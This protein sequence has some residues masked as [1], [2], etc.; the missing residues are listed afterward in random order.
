VNGTNEYALVRTRAVGDPVSRLPGVPW[1]NGE[2][3]PGNLEFKFWTSR[4]EQGAHGEMDVW[5][6]ERGNV[7]AFFKVDPFRT[8]VLQGGPLDVLF[9]MT[10]NN[11][12]IREA[13]RNSLQFLDQSLKASGI[14][15][16]YGIILM[17]GNPNVSGATGDEFYDYDAFTTTAGGGYWNSANFGWNFGDQ[18]AGM[19]TIKN[20]GTLMDWTPGASRVYVVVTANAAYDYPPGYVE[21]TSTHRY[22]EALDSLNANSVPLFGIV[23][24]NAAVPINPFTFVLPSNVPQSYMAM[25][26]ATGGQSYTTTDFT[27]NGTAIMQSLAEAMRIAS[28]VVQIG[29]NLN[30]ISR[31]ALRKVFNGTEA[32]WPYRYV[33]E[34]GERITA[35][36]ESGTVAYDG[37]TFV[38]VGP[39]PGISSSILNAS[40][41]S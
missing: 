17:R 41:T 32:H 1:Y 18:P 39:D 26:T 13:F 23:N 12:A 34:D 28:F 21:P 36:Q 6:T 37:K 14:A 33:A 16:K 2:F 9:V 3:L 20:A 30:D 29:T 8:L 27:A 15:P 24:P 11:S 4:E 10:F 31:N 22:T 19:I 7:P 5:L 35:Y 40:P 25:A 38:Q